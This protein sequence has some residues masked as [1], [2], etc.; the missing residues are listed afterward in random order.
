MTGYNKFNQDTNIIGIIGHPIK[1]SYSPLMHNISFEIKNLNY[2]YLPF[3]VPIN[4]LKA[5]IKGM[6]ALGIK[7]FNITLPH[8]ENIIA[9]LRNVSEE[10]SI[11]GA[12]NTVVND[13]GILSGYNT[14]VNGVYETLLPYKDEITGQKVS[15]FGA[16]GGARSVIYTLIRNFKPEKIQIINRTEQKGESL[17][18]YFSTRMHFT[19]IKSYELIPPD[20]VDVLRDSKLIIN[21]TSVGMYPNVDDSVTSIPQS[22]VKGQVVFDLIYNPLKTRLL[23]LAESQGATV[24][25]G[26]RM[27][28]HQG[29]KSFELWTGEEMPVEKINKAL[30]LYIDTK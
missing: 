20:L 24:I 30:K 15:I 16:G 28:V 4:T 6:V 11:I 2:I 22:F 13:N 9:Y 26:L 3:D 23:Q 21:T 10:A 25:D 17:R 19:D 12:V 5:A 8:K 27:L 18:E 7:G 1:H 14:D 29:A